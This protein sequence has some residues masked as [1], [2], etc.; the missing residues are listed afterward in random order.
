[1]ASKDSK[2]SKKVVLTLQLSLPF[3]PPVAGVEFVPHSVVRA[4]TGLLQ[5]VPPHSFCFSWYRKEPFT[6]SVHRSESATV[7]CRCCVKLNIPVEDSYHCSPQCFRHAWKRHA[8]SH[9]NANETVSGTTIVVQQESGEPSSSA[10]ADFDHGKSFDENLD[11]EGVGW[12]KVGSSKIYEPTNDDIDFPLKLECT[13]VDHA[14]G[15]SLVQTIV[16]NPVISFP[17]RSPR[18][19][20][21][22][23]GDE[24]HGN[25][26][27]RSQSSNGLTFRVLS[28]N[29]L[30]SIYAPSNLGHC[31]AWALAWQYRR[32]NLLNE[33]I[34]YDADVICLQEVQNDHL[35]NF[36]EPELTKRGYS[37]LFKKKTSNGVFSGLY[38][39]NDGCATFY[40]CDLFREI[41]KSELEFEGK[42]KMLVEESLGPDLAD[43][44]RLIKD[45]VALIVI[46]QTL[47]NGSADND[48]PSRICVANTHICANPDLPDVKV[49]QVATL[50]RELEEIVESKIPLLICAD[51]NSCPGSNPHTL[52]TKG[53]LRCIEG[54]NPLKID[55][56]IK[57]VHQMQ[58]E[59]AYASFL[60]SRG[61]DQ[62]H[63]S[64][65]DPN[66]L[67]PLFTNLTPTFSGTLDY[68]LYTADSFKVEGLLEL[69]GKEILGE[70]YLPSPYW[71]SDHVALMAQLRLLSPN[72]SSKH[73]P[74]TLK[75]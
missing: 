68:I 55:R 17:H 70:G 74:P 3:D 75:K 47:K 69:P 64:K 49:F 31:P 40:R 8:M 65:M 39:V 36:F 44:I 5:D 26:D 72:A 11:L 50:I 6:C 51:L 16:T 28:Y 53:R 56:F 48:L 12:V 58:L 63:S 27:L 61:I 73:Q 30:A 52:L 59:S 37:V 2:E 14:K 25:I 41:M 42:G 46:L 66:N 57:L 19:M 54:D 20:I 9:R 13:A 62:K 21:A 35:K 32:K 22:I 1:M 24:K 34:E 33:I 60:H 67:E 29:I 45:N 71:S 18:Q 43:C 38:F 7:Q 10:W 4:S 23:G 15:T